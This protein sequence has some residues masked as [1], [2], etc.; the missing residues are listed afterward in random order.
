MTR[1]PQPSR[2]AAASEWTVYADALQEANDPRGEL[3]ALNKA[4]A[5]GMSPADRDAYVAR[6]KDALF[7]PAVAANLDDYTIT[8]H[9]GLIDGVDIRARS[10]ETA[11]GLVEALLALPAAASLRSFTLTPRWPPPPRSSPPP[12]ARSRS[13]TS[14]RARPP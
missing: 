8:W 6:H 3:I 14:A 12:A 1:V 10:T 2:D 11:A 9:F 13:S 5:E 7:G 4:V